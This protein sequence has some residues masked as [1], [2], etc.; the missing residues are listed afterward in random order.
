ME[1]TAEEKALWLSDAS[2]G[3]GDATANGVETHAEKCCTQ[4]NL[5][6]KR[7]NNYEHITH[8]NDSAWVQG[9][10]VHV[11]INAVQIRTCPADYTNAACA[12]APLVRAVHVR[13]IR[14]YP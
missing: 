2:N 11:S 1:T 9:A 5:K 13:D 3:I 6:K 7:N 4:I 10:N 12:R 14:V 8:G